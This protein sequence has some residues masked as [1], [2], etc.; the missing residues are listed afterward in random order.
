MRHRV[1]VNITL[2]EGVARI[3]VGLTGVVGA[4]VLLAGSPGGAAA[5]LVVL[6]GLAGL[7]L[8]VTG[9]F[10]HCPLYARLGLGASPPAA[11][12]E[13]GGLP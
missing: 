11:G 12:T 7:D 3:V 2:Q 1:A 6:L 9:A 4:V 5:V 10:G 8:I 13:G